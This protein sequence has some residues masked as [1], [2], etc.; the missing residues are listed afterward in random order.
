ML[1]IQELLYIPP[2]SRPCQPSGAYTHTSPALRALPLL[3]PKPQ[4]KYYTP[5]Q[6]NKKQIKITL[7][8]IIDLVF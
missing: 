2:A 4:T 5:Q 3:I 1:E 7:H 6:I 8:S